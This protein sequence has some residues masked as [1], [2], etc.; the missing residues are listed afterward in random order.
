MPEKENNKK[1]GGQKYRDLSTRENG[2]SLPV[3]NIKLELKDSLQSGNV[4]VHS[5]K[6]RPAEFMQSYSQCSAISAPAHSS[7][8]VWFFGTGAMHGTSIGEIIDYIPDP[9]RRVCLF[10]TK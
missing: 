9:T 3:V 2:E 6:P 7:S 5:C 4:P 1:L 8:R 10:K